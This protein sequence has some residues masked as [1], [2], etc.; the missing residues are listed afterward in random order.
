MTTSDNPSSSNRASS[1][2]A[3]GNDASGN[4]ASGNHSYGNYGYHNFRCETRTSD[5]A[6]ERLVSPVRQ[7]R[8]TAALLIALTVATLV[9][10]VVGVGGNWR[11]ILTTA[12]VLL[13]PGWAITAYLRS[14][15]LSFRWGVGIAL[16][17]AIGMIAGQTM[18]VGH[19]WNPSVAMFV[20]GV[21]SLAGL[22][23]HLVRAPS[24]AE[25]S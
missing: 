21:L 23:H 15:P 10:E 8:G 2:R 12:F 4:C 3:S 7:R 18:V 1:N 19:A 20:I 16:G 13:A 9:A 17:V 6:T 24:A 14:A 5:T 11:L 25:L 22:V